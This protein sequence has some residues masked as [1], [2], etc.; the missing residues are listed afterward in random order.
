MALSLLRRSAKGRNE[1]PSKADAG[2]RT[3]SSVEGPSAS[4]DDFP[5]SW[6]ILLEVL[7]DGIA[8]VDGSGVI[9]YANDQLAAICGYA[10]RELVG[11]TVDFL[12][13]SL[14]KTEHVTLLND[15][16]RHPMRRKTTTD[17]ELTLVRSDTSEMAVHLDRSP[18][19]FAG[20][21]WQVV[22]VRDLY[23]QRAAELAHAE[24][25]LR[26]H[27]AF[28]GNA[29]PMTVTNLDDHITAVNDAFCLMVGYSRE[30][31]LGQDSR[32]F[33]YPEDVG[34]TE[35][36][37]RRAMFG[38]AHQ[39]RY[40]KRY[41]R[42]DK[43]VIFVEV[44][45]APARDE[46]GQLL[47]F[48]FS[49]RDITEERALSAQLSHQALHDP[50]T[51]LANR[52][53]FMDRLAQAHAR[54]S[55]Q[56]GTCAVLVMDLDNFK[57][58]NDTYGHLVG[59]Q[60]LVAIAHRLTQSSRSSD[61]LCRSGDDEFLYLAEGLASPEDAE[62][63][64][65]RLLQILTEP[66]TFADVTIEQHASLGVVLW[67]ASCTDQAEL[68]QNADVALFEAKR[69]GKGRHVTFEA[70]MDKQAVN[71]FELVQELRQAFNA[72]EIS[73]H[74]QPIVDL[75]TTAVVGFEALMRWRHPQRGLVPPI[76]FIPLAEQSDLILELGTFALREAIAAAGAWERKGLESNW[77]YITVNLSA[78]QF[79]DPDLVPVIENALYDNGL[80]PDRLIIEI[81]ERVALL[82]IAETLDVVERLNRLGVGFA[83]DDFGTGYSSLSYLALMRPRIIK[84][85]QA[86]VSPALE[87]VRNDTL[88]EAIVS[89]GQKLN[90]SVLAEGIE[91]RRQFV[92][93]QCFGCELG[94]GF[95]FSPAVPSTEAAAMVGRVLGS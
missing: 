46:N 66:F 14:K 16:H 6:H 67:D 82:D 2:S 91:T 27:M 1:S 60:L 9:R 71:R 17:V 94:Q 78:R 81:T 49:E 85:D 25:E 35:E 92:R 18:F 79:Q 34:I 7:P 63:V 72:G 47:Y 58:V 44:S 39:S 68:I 73:M 24:A 86:F 62:L 65:K 33:T 40:I 51:G 10:R 38:E 57:G 37:H 70:G 56:G 31:L 43:R 20:E 93:L 15:H 48:V 3:T 5:L 32:F 29:A 8:F 61:S 19:T 84:I 23:A 75:T 83:L 89:M 95:L 88:L 54:V 59:D 53:L 30:E 74:Y 42:K 12:V 45:R 69:T 50:L 26:F 77:P 41:L 36:S 80:S 22:T 55:R 13:P 52:A 11:Q 4:L 87:S 76:V 28:D 21:T 64:A 90:M